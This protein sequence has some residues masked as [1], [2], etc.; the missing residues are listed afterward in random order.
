MSNVTGKTIKE[1]FLTIEPR[2][3]KHPMPGTSMEVW[4]YELTSYE[5]ETWREICR[6][7]D[8]NMRRLNAAKLLQLSLRDAE[9]NRIFDEEEIAIIGGKP[10][11][12]IEPLT[13]IILRLSGYGAEA[14]QAILKNLRKILGAAGLSDLLGSSTA[15][16]GNSTADIPPTSSESSGSPSS[17]GPSVPPPKDSKQS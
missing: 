8:D 1:A 13:K 4:V 17:S 3:E 12:L 6:A 15:A 2:K 7:E 5:L 16:S 11:H 14:D 9:G 10:A